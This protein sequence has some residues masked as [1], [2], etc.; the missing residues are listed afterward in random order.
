MIA[1]AIT[2][3]AQVAVSAMLGPPASR[4]CSATAAGKTAK[5]CR[6][7][8]VV[9]AEAIHPSAERDGPGD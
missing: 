4:S 3:P 7:P 5:T 1:A 6:C 2:G 9:T 8:L